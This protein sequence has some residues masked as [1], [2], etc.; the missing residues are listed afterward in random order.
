MRHHCGWLNSTM[1]WHCWVLSIPRTDA[2]HAPDTDEIHAGIDSLPG[3]STIIEQGEIGDRP[4]TGCGKRV[5]FF[6][7]R[8]AQCN[9]CAPALPR[10][11]AGAAS[12]TSSWPATEFQLPLCKAVD[13][14]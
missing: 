12:G 10:L 2:I 5:G 11:C 13:P 8:Q 9:Q 3:V 7:S 14:A 6:D 4:P 1:I